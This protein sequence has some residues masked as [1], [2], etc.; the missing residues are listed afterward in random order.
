M[1]AVDWREGVVDGAVFRGPHRSL[2]FCADWAPVRAYAEAL[3]RRPGTVYSDGVRAEL[4]KAG[5]RIVNVETV[6][7]PRRDAVAPVFKEGPNF[8][9]PA[10]AVDD[11]RAAG[12][13][14]ALL[15]NNH[16]YDFGAEGLA[17]TR[18]VL[19]SAGL[20]TCGAGRSQEDAYDGVVLDG[21]KG[22][23]VALVNFQEGE[24]GGWT[25]RAP[26]L[27]GWDLDR[28]CAS[29]RRHAAA[30]RVVVAVP[31]ADREFLPFPAPYVQRAYRRLVE[32]GASLVVAHHPHVPRGVEI[33]QGVP[34][35]YSQGNFV[36][37]HDHPGLFRRLGYMLRV[38][39]G[40]DGAV[41]CRI[42]PYRLDGGGI[43]LLDTEQQNW[44][45]RQLEAVS[46][47]ALS[48]D[49]VL[50]WWHAAIDAI[51]LDSWYA[52]CTGMKYGMDLMARRDP[53]GL[54]R[55]RTRLSSPAHYQFMVAGIDRILAGDHGGSPP[56]MVG[57][58]RLW[59]E[60]PVSDFAAFA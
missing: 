3:V 8:I 35:F 9:G 39:V 40:A 55:L 53:V 29:I 21:G 31:H 45:F 37:N 28:V 32:A 30:G 26:G 5:L 11:L 23:P 38:A 59:T 19:E 20:R 43:H 57:K 22:A 33:H 1:S 52:D 51:P 48:P 7:H 14:I 18:E 49:S 60:A 46:G 42:V 44:F 12:F 4:A 16:S 17:A 6:L 15:A 50:A 25:E 36:F 41:G 56:E 34:I 24:E 58:V 2:L 10:V 54:A 27:A 13:D 47:E